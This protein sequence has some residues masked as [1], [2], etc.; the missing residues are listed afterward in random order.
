MKQTEIYYR[1][2]GDNIKIVDFKS[3]ATASQIKEL[4]DDV[5]NKYFD[6]MKEYYYL[7]LSV[8][9]ISLNFKLYSEQKPSLDNIV[10][11]HSYHINTFDEIIKSMK[12][13]GNRLMGLVKE[14]SKI[15]MV[16]I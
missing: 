6:P 13:A 5:Y 11:G 14:Q 2:N 10:I 4:G 12:R 7:D 3:V 1:K 9:A 15:R 8:D 16:K